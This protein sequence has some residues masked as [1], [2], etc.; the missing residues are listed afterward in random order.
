MNRNALIVIF[1]LIVTG[2]LAVWIISGQSFMDTRSHGTGAHDDHTSHTDDHDAHGHDTD[3]HDADRGPHGGRLLEDDDFSIEITVFETGLP[4]EFHVYAYRDGLPLPPAQVELQIEL[5]RLGGQVDRFSFV[6]QQDYLRGN[7]VVT[8][9]HSFDVA[10]VAEYGGHTYRWSYENHE[11]RTQIPKGMAIE[12]GIETETAGPVTIREILS[13]TGQVQTDPDRLSR[14]RPRF[15][16]V[17]QTVR[18]NLG[19]VVQAGDVLATVQSNESLETYRIKAPIGGLIVRR[20][21]QVGEATGDEP[22][23]IIA[24]LTG[25]WVELDVFGRDLQRVR[26]GQAVEIETF[27]DYRAGGEIDWLSPMSAHASQSVRARVRLANPEGRLRPGQFVRGRIT[28]AEH[29]VPLAVRL[30]ALQRF[31]DFQVIFARIGDTYEVRM[32]EL[33]RRDSEWVEV[34]GGLAPGTEYVT[35]NSYLI[36]ADIEKSGASHDH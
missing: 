22:L 19:D 18:R 35:A 9:P 10:V 12:S 5:T 29:A 7:E 26:A 32:L 15:P 36:K 33:G 24:D 16:G 17:V 30:A 20:D 8:E 4:P 21:I 28:L 1:I 34:L 2:A 3:A 25:V 13:L 6:P 27:D 11:G 31:R 14:V 23:F